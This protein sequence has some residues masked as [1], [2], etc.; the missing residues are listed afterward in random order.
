MIY[1]I[2]ANRDMQEMVYVKQKKIL[3]TKIQLQLQVQ[4]QVQVQVQTKKIF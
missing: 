4:L 3:K 1:Q 2:M